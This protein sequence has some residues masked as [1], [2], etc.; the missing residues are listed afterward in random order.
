MMVIG[1]GIILLIGNRT[2]VLPTFPFAG[3]LT[4][5]VGGMIFGIGWRGR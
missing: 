3:F 4:M 1:V 2:G 5:T